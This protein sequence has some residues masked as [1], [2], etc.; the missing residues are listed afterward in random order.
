MCIFS[1]LGGIC[2]CCEEVK[3]YRCLL[4][5]LVTKYEITELTLRFKIDEPTWPWMKANGVEAMK[6]ESVTNM[7]T[8]EKM[9]HFTVEK[10]EANDRQAATDEA[11][12][13]SN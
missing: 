1:A 10:G 11:R 3:Y 4:S 7:K 9:I 13:D 12:K 5:Y 2:D 8:L 6:F